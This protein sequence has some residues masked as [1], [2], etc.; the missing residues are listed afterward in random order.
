MVLTMTVL[1]GIPLVPETD[2]FIYIELEYLWD[3]YLDQHG[4][5]VDLWRKIPIKVYC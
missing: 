3:R 4:C 1:P 5:V 2:G